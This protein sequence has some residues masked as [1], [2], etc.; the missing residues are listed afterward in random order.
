MSRAEQ[1]SADMVKCL[2]A[3]MGYDRYCTHATRNGHMT[4]QI[5]ETF[6]HHRS[7]TD[8]VAMETYPY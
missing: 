1:N 8:L 4:R 6:R 3:D 2:N 7:S 5:D